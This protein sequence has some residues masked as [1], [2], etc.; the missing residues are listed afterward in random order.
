MLGTWIEIPENEMDKNER[1]RHT[2]FQSSPSF[3]AEDL[4]SECTSPS[5]T[6][7]TTQTLFFD[8]AEAANPPLGQL[9][10]H[11][12]LTGGRLPCATASD[13]QPS[14]LT[15]RVLPGLTFDEQR[16][17]GKPGAAITRTTHE[18]ESGPYIAESNSGVS[19][20][21]IRSVRSGYLR[22]GSG[23]NSSGIGS[24]DAPLL[25]SQESS[26]SGVIPEKKQDEEKAAAK[27]EEG[28]SIEERDDEGN[29]YPGR[30][31]LT[32]IIIGLC[33]SVF[34]ISLDRTIITTVRIQSP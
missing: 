31:P 23:S 33:L 26:I 32:F 14:N 10:S 15:N 17:P 9:P 1:P 5:N 30:L 19:T 7:C 29:L 2:P 16:H 4:H 11:S 6:S 13:P 34:L 20:K 12:T 24:S 22:A 25:D 28:K 18:V 27:K 3:P 8:A 21:D